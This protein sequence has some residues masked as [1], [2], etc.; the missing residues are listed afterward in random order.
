MNP[1]TPTITWPTP[2]AITYGTALSAAQLD[3]SASVQGLFSYSP[4]AGS[5]P[6][7]GTQTLSVTF[8]P[9]D[10]TDYATVTAT[11]SLTVSQATPAVS[12]VA[13]TA[14]TYG[15]ALS[16]VQLD[17]TSPVAGTF[18]YSPVSATVLKAGV[19]TLSVTFTPTDLTDYTTATASV[20]LMVNQ[21]IPAITWATPAA[22]TY[23]TALST[24]QLDA[25]SPVAGGFVYAPVAG[26]VLK[27]G[28]QT[29][30]VTF[31]PTDAADYK[32]TTATVSLTVNQ[33][34][35]TISWS[36][37]V[38][39]TYGTALSATQLDA[40]AS[41]AG[42]FVYSPAL[43]AVKGAGTQILSVTF[44]P[45]DATDY[46]TAAAS[47]TITVLKAALIV[48]PISLNSIY[49]A[50]LPTLTDT[51]SGF[52]NGD[53]AATAVTGSANL[54]TTATSA[55]AVGAYP[56]TAAL[57]TL[58]AANYNFRFLG[59]TLTVRPAVLTVTATSS[60]K[61]YA[62]A[63]PTLTDTISGFANGD[64]AATAV[65]GAP[66]LTTVATA[67]YNVGA[68]AITPAKGTL[69]ASN[70]SFAFVPGIL[71]ITP[72]VLTV[73][74]NNAS[75]IYGAALPGL[76]YTITGFVNGD[77]QVHAVTGT[78]TVTTTATANSAAGS[79]P[80]TP[81]PGTLTARDYTFTFVA[82]TLTVNPATL[83]V[84]ASNLSKVYG[85]PL[86]SFADTVTGFVN[87]D[88][89]SGAVTGAATFNTTATPGSAVGAY[90][91]T[92]ALGTL[93]A[94]NYS[95]KFV[96]GTLT[97]TKAGLIF[98]ASSLNSVYGAALPTLTGTFSGLVN[99]DTAATA[100]TGSA[101]LTTAAT[102]ASPVGAYPITAALGT[103]S[104]ANYNFRFLGGTL[105]VRPAV[106]TV[107]A[108]SFSKIYAAA[109]PTLT[110]TISGFV[111]GDT[112]A[113]AVTGT[114]TLSTVATAVYNVGAYAITP[115]KGTLAASNYS[116]AFVP[117]TLTITPAVLTVTANN[118]SKIYGAALPGL[119]YAITG[120]VNGDL[121]VHAVTGTA[122]V[123]TTAT[124][125][126]A[127]GSYPI[128]PAL[129]TLAARD[130]TFTFVAG[131]L[132]VT[133]AALTIAANNLTVAYNQPIPGLTYSVS[134]FVNGD[135]PTVLSGAPTEMTTAV[136]G[137][138]P[139]TYPISIT[140]GTLSAANYTLVG[141][142]ATLTI[143]A[144][145]S[146]ANTASGIAEGG[147]ARARRS[148]A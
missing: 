43:G 134:G 22:I 96:N 31:T 92:P 111:N 5:V 101:S 125:A 13:P 37:P 10:S 25:A 3:A 69:A 138:A 26:T 135:V 146:A 29:L 42:S 64:T 93:S 99:G 73:T 114:P 74:A 115:A 108:T 109:M 71:T 123:T 117:G 143:T 75:K 45:T 89:L 132:T 141:K 49:G 38:A 104:A 67:A 4:A 39:V 59:G 90:P 58:S 66:T 119:G 88:T 124:A 6:K 8:T 63:M 68:Y 61:V 15:T 126:S 55:S 113:S 136:Q 53:T 82:G 78:A 105:T 17:A 1:A 81:A 122:V 106:L 36:S 142:S 102:P 91:I 79:Y 33:A 16:A 14:I 70:Y 40:T 110:D 128:T 121:Q 46:S 34:K 100:V 35:P 54:T 2:A 145:A 97:I 86:P 20:S 12:W 32:S 87:G 27:A 28:T 120:F 83:T 107:T 98:T 103:L 47:V 56:I 112:A 18:T 140:R 9:T 19:Q 51:F 148:R 80:I 52:V 62:A 50:A 44:T 11:V 76:G 139:G 95:F 147:R 137:S 24:T 127:V 133:P 129:G 7:A 57:G 130:Y 72:A 144:Q 84:T 131:T 85:A 77:L 30:S 48:T 116:F 60:S 94:A 65:T 21:A 118:A 41:V 23:G